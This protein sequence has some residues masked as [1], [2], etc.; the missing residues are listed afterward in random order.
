MEWT[1]RDHPDRPTSVE[2]ELVPPRVPSWI[3]VTR[4]V[5]QRARIVIQTLGETHTAINGLDVPITGFEWY[6]ERG[7]LWT[8]ARIEPGGA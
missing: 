3:G 2:G 6:D 7:H 5:D 8:A 4:V 1:W